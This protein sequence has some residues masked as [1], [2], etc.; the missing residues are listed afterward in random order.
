MRFFQRN[1]KSLEKRYQQAIEDKDQGSLQILA[2]LVEFCG[3]SILSVLF[4]VQNSHS[5]IKKTKTKKHK[6]D[7]K[8]DKNFGFEF[9]FFVSMRL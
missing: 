5:K 1:Q 2:P 6:V 9:V 7:V 8:S 4:S 3:F